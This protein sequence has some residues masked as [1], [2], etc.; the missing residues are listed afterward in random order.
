[1]LPSLLSRISE[2]HNSSFV[3]R[4][5]SYVAPDIASDIRRHFAQNL[6]V[7]KNPNAYYVTEFCTFSLPSEIEDLPVAIQEQ[8][9]NELLD[10]DAQQQLESIPA[11][12]NWSREISMNLMSR[13]YVLW[14]RSA[15]DCLLDSAMQATYGIF[16]RENVLRRAL[17]D[18]LNQCSQR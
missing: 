11:A 13:L 15:G 18:T 12:L 8:L 9:Y 10:K 16:D 1:M 3:K 7:R 6:R 14:N 2:T 17:S 5:P 4:V